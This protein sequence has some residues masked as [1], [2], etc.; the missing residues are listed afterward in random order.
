VTVGTVVG[1]SFLGAVRAELRWNVCSPT[2]AEVDRAGVA[3]RQNPAVVDLDAP[4]VVTH[5]RDQRSAHAPTRLVCR[6]ES[7]PVHHA[8]HHG[9]DPLELVI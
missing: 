3:S 4:N 9:T 8:G 2:A 6:A 7:R 5:D 1:P